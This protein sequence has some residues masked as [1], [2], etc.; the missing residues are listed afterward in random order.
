MGKRTSSAKAPS[1]TS[2]ESVKIALES[3]L[4]PA[5]LF[6]QKAIAKAILMFCSHAD[7]SGDA[8]ALFAFF[9]S[10][11]DLP[12][13]EIMT[14]SLYPTWTHPGGRRLFCRGA[15]LAIKCCGCNV[16]GH[17]LAYAQKFQARSHSDRIAIP[18]FKKTFLRP[19][20]RAPRF[21]RGH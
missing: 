14:G 8:E 6:G 19:A 7:A 17:S 3:L 15:F 5:F 9:S 10:V 11:D 2:L 21:R 18:V 12:E 13:N 20:F 1:P 16:V 4:I